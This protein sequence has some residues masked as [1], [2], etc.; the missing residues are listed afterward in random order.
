MNFYLLLNTGLQKDVLFRE[1]KLKR[2]HEVYSFYIILH[3]GVLAS[4]WP[5]LEEIVGLK[6]TIP[7]EK[8]WV[9]TYLHL[10]G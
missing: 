8:I 3:L 10:A 1:Q 9:M 5:F 4:S 2:N 6:H 7:F